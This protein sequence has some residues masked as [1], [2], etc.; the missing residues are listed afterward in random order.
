MTI[1]D[2]LE[3]FSI[4]L[5]FSILN[6][7]KPS[8][9]SSMGLMIFF[10]CLLIIICCYNLKSIFILNKFQK[11]IFSLFQFVLGLLKDSIL[12]KKY[13]F[14]LLFYSTFLFIFISNILGM[15]PY[16][17]TITSRFYW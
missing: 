10:I 1:F 9:F 4:E 3:Q 11:I 6:D 5:K 12:I 16:S 15:I 8:S 13:S 7:L 17:M 2:P 14:V